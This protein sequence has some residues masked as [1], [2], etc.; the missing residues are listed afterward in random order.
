MDSYKTLAIAAIQNYAV[1]MRHFNTVDK[2]FSENTGQG[3]MSPQLQ[4]EMEETLSFLRIQLEILDAQ[5]NNVDNA[6]EC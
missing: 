2:L 5:E 6:E 3:I 4:L 1:L